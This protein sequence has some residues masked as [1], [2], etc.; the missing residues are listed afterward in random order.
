MSANLILPYNYFPHNH[1]SLKSRNLI[2]TP[3]LN[4]TIQPET[5][6]QARQIFGQPNLKALISPMSSPGREVVDGKNDSTKG[7]HQALKAGPTGYCSGKN[8]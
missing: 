5:G 7:L 2:L 1:P 6:P 8:N 3:C 4:G